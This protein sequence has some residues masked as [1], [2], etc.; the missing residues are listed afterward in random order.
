MYIGGVVKHGRRSYDTRRQVQSPQCSAGRLIPEGFTNRNAVGPRQLT[1]TLAGIDSEGTHAEFP[2]SAQQGAVVRPDINYQTL[3]RNLEFFH[4]VF[5]KVLK[6]L[7][8]GGIQ[9]GD[10]WVIG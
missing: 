2:E 8:N 9:A 7:H 5:R 6:M 10:V 1:G 3:R 4:N